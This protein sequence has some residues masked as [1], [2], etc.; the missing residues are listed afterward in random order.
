MD[1]W[2]RATSIDIVVFVRQWISHIS[3]QLIHRVDILHLAMAMGSFSFLLSLSLA[4]YIYST[5]ILFVVV[6]S[7]IHAEASPI[8]LAIRFPPHPHLAVF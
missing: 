5:Q 6:V 4:T 1:A 8:H 7:Q 2:N 3:N